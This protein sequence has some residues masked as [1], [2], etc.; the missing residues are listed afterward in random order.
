MFLF[1]NVYYYNRKKKQKKTS[2]IYVKMDGSVLKE[3]PSCKT[4]LTFFSNL[5]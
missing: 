1:V 4:R 3:K 2:A 5:V